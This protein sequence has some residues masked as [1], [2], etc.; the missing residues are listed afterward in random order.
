MTKEKVT[1]YIE[2]NLKGIGMLDDKKWKEIIKRGYDQT[3]KY[4]S[5]IA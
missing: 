2:L 5:T 4:L 1:H 3:K